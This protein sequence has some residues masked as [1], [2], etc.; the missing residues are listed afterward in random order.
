M[1]TN[2][3]EG[4]LTAFGGLEFLAAGCLEY[5]AA[6]LNDVGYILGAEIHNLVGDKAAIA[7]VNAFHFEAAEYSGASDGTDSGIHA[8]S[9]AS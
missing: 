4:E 7:T 1:T 9:V 3:I 6:L 5:C 2:H 8:G